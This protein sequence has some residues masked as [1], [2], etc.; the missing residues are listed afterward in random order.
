MKAIVLQQTGGVENLVIKEVPV[1]AIKDNEVLI[2]N[3]AIAINPVDAFVRGNAGALQGIVRPAEGADI[4][5]GWDIAGEVVATG[6][7]VKDFKTGDAVFGM[8]NF[9]GQGSAYAEYVAAP[10]DHVALKP[11]NTTYEKAAAAS[12]AALT[13]WQALV[14]HGQV[15]K[16]DKV[17]IH[18]AA[19]GVGHYAVQIA[20]HFGAYVIG[21]ASAAKKE[22]V[23]SFG[24]NEYIDYNQQPFESLVTDADIVLDSLGIPG[25]LERS[26][27]AV[28]NNGR[29]ISLL[30]FPDDAFKQQAAAKNVYVHR[31]TV[32]SDGK[33]ISSIASLLEQG[34]L[35]SDIA[36]TFPFEEMG[37][38]HEKV[39]GGKTQGKIV[40]NV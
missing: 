31:L 12:L 11:A 34:A 33:D 5:L 10:A 6:K 15:K 16:G 19:G 27:S 39:A 7:D 40:V 30:V 9:P 2:Q 25:H 37:K 28:K 26:L 17:L 3:K 21:T 35:H 1:P 13:A 29:L 8:V 14:V 24:A 36:E 20:K 32:N 18:A 4:I 23:L 22:G 38:A